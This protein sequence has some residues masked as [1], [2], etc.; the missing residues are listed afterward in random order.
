MVVPLLG[1]RYA[2]PGAVFS[3]GVGYPPQVSLFFCE[4]SFFSFVLGRSI[5]HSAI[6]IE[7]ADILLPTLAIFEE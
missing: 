3:T 5:T 6:R 2:Q 7:L 1:P 4:I